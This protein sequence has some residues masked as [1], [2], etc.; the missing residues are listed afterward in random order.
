MKKNAELFL[1]KPKVSIGLIEAVHKEERPYYFSVSICNDYSAIIPIR[2]SFSHPYGFITKSDYEDDVK[3]NSGLDYTKSI[4]ILTSDLDS[5][6]NGIATID[7]QE[8]RKINKFQHIIKRGYLSYLRK[9][10]SII[11]KKHNNERLR[12]KE[13]LLIQFSTLQNYHQILKE[14]F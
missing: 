9:Y 14:E 5:I 4:L 7:N 8:Y 12:S 3:I 1:I 10:K 6:K 11:E 2:S 13:K